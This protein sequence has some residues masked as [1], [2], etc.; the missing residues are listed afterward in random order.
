MREPLWLVIAAIGLASP[1]DAVINPELTPVHLVRQAEQVWLLKLQAADRAAGLN[2]EVQKTLVG[3]PPQRTPVLDLSA[4]LADAQVFR[5]RA[6]GNEAL[7]FVAKP[8]GP[9]NPGNRIGLLHVAGRWHRLIG[10]APL[11]WQWDREDRSLDGTWNGGTQMLARAIEYILVD[12][13]ANIPA[14]CDAAWGQAQPIAMVPR[15]PRLTSVDGDFD[16]DGL[17]D[18]LQL[19]ADHATFERGRIEGAYLP[20]AVIANLR[21]L[22]EPRCMA[23]GD[24]EADERLDVLVCASEGCSLWTNRGDGAFHD[25]LAETGELTA[26]ATAKASEAHVCDLNNDGRQ[27][28]LVAYA[29][30]APQLYFNR[31]F[32]CFVL[33]TELSLDKHAELAGGTQATAVADFNGDGCQDLAAVTTQ[34]S[35]VLVP[36]DPT[37]GNKL[38]VTINLPPTVS[39][40]LA[41][42]A[43]DGKRPLGAQLLRP[44]QPA[45]FGKTN[46][47][48]LTLSW[49]TAANESRSKPVIVLKPIQFTIDE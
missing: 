37:K 34:G 21:P 20:P 45:F 9:A 22:G 6:V 24:F 19:L 3:A 10:R 2:L 11:V 26:L 15:L 4:M 27:D 30:R 46:K 40:P 33:A 39:T 1:A 47:G 48:P 29:D 17:G 41:I 36:R 35:L 28:I 23:I 49:R 5:A 43:R 7:L 18:R 38:G 44:G 16:G 14:S 13:G 25:T 12:P 8:S 31:G 32:R 42:W